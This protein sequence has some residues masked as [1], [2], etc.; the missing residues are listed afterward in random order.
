MRAAVFVLLLTSLAAQAQSDMEKDIQLCSS[1]GDGAQRL[2]C[3]DAMARRQADAASPSE[4]FG[5]PKPPPKEADSIRS[6]L[7]GQFRGW[8]PGSVFTLENGQVWKCTGDDRA[9]YPDVPLNPEIVISKSYF[10]AYWMEI[11]AIG[12]KIKVKRLK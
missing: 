6:R 1:M 12:R 9:Y 10:G 11:P 5:K 3:Y 4:D 8:E 2:E 7:V